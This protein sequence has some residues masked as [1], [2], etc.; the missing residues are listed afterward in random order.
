MIEN[1]MFKVNEDYGTMTI[2][3]GTYEL[4]ISDVTPNLPPRM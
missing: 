1:I 4:A 3:S 2:K